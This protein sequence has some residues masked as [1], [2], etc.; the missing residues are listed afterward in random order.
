[1]SSA[2]LHPLLRP[3]P[4]KAGLVCILACCLLWYSFGYE[5]PAIFSAIDARIVDAMFR[6]RGSQATTG[7]VVIVDIDERS[8]KAHGQWPW[9]RN[10]VAD[11]TRK[12]YASGS[13]VVGFD[14]LFAERDRTSP[15]TL[16]TRHLGILDACGDVDSILQTARGRQE[17]D[18]DGM[19]GAS[20]AG[21]T[22]VLGYMFLFREDSLKTDDRTPFPSL[23]VSLA[24]DTAGFADLKLIRAY[25]P[26]L[27]IPEIATASSEGFFNVFPD[28]SGT[29]RKVPLFLMLADVPYPSLAFEMFR[30]ALGEQQALLHLSGIGKA[31]SRT[32]MGVS[33]GD[34]F[35][36][37]DDFGNLTVNFRGPYNTFTYVSATDV[38]QGIDTDKLLDKFVLIGSSASGIMDLIAT[39]FASR[40][41]GVEV[42]ANVIDNLLMGD[43][44]VWENY[45]EIGLTYFLIITAGLLLIVSLV[46]LGPFLGYAAGLLI[47]AAIVIGNYHYLFVKHQL[48]GISYILASLLAVFMTVS[49]LNY[50]FEGRR[51]LFIRRAFSHYVSPSIVNELVKN[52]E[53]LNL[54]VE[55]REV[56]ILFCDIRNFTSLS[57]VTSATELGGFLNRFFSL[58]T[59]IIIKHDGMVDKYIGDAIMAVWGTP[60]DD[61]HHADNAVQAGLE[62]VAAIEGGAG[63]RLML[64]GKAIE[65]GIGIN[66]GQVSVGNF[67]SSRRFAYTVLGDNV[68]LA[69]RIEGLTKFYKSRILISEFT[70]KALPAAMRY[71][72]IDTVMVKGRNRQVDLFEPLTSQEAM[73]AGSEE[74]DYQRALLLFRSRDFI[75]AGALFDGLYAKRQ[76]WLYALYRDRCRA[77]SEIPPPPEWK[78]VHVHT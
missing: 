48:L 53:K 57:E 27:N 28:Q 62:M 46:Y 66:T 43:A 4:F 26:L 31:K 71:R 1:M 38:L 55:S 76:E 49:L 2:L 15:I 40:V 50:F 59:D 12:I 51:R 73:A 42:H 58:M 21:G 11:L 67:G 30:L 3:T 10:I 7:A 24:S 77:F 64:A 9:P 60:L 78:G 35:I 6:V 19:F 23:T 14:I 22:A 18:H 20:I 37:T 70:A 13:K 17:F 63:G 34:T 54:S 29:V 68:N 44:M 52:P 74:A 47:L 41:P 56:T 45:T 65:I 61:R 8:L 16:L 5:K 39:P 69:S 75:Q 33:L 36:R 72:F 25:R 32:L